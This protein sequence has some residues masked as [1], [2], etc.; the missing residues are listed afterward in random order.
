MS[1][2][3]CALYGVILVL[4]AL[5]TM[6]QVALL[7]IVVGYFGSEIVVLQFDG[8]ES[9]DSRNLKTEV[10][11]PI[12]QACDIIEGLL[13]LF[14]YKLE[15]YCGFAVIDLHLEVLKCT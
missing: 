1:A 9:F 11:L 3:Q 4:P 13:G 14:T 2:R 12:F 5:D 7:M 6:C 8:Y 15:K 10:R